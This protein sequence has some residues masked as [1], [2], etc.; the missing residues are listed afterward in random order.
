MTGPKVS[1]IPKDSIRIGKE[2]SCYLSSGID[3]YLWG[4]PDV[5]VYDIYFGQ[6][7]AGCGILRNTI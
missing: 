2:N 1:D 6:F 5:D 7:R 3:Y 4:D